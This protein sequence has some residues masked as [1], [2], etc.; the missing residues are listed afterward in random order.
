[1]PRQMRREFA[2]AIYHVMN[3]GDRLRRTGRLVV[4]KALPHPGLPKEKENFR[5]VFEKPAI[6]F[7][8]HTPPR[9]VAFGNPASF[10]DEESWFVLP[11]TLCQANVHCRFATTAVGDHRPQ[12]RH[13]EGLV[14]GGTGQTGTK[15]LIKSFLV[16]YILI[17]IPL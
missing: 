10:Q 2:G 16:R 13:R 7:A 1:M 17:N 4:S 5:R 3:R 15:W 8:G 9:M 6:G 12:V 11:C 14:A